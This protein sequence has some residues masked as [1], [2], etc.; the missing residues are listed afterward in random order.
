MVSVG[1]LIVREAKPGKEDEL[2]SFLAGAL[3]L[4]R[5]EAADNGTRAA[6]SVAS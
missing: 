2:A 1:L 6:S 3:P 5:T 4:V